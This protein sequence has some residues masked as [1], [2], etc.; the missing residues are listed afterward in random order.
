MMLEFFIAFYHGPQ[1][2][3]RLG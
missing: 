3:N 1:Q 2:V